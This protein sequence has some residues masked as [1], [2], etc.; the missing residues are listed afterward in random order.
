[1]ERQNATLHETALLDASIYI[2]GVYRC[3]L[4]ARFR[5]LQDR[6]YRMVMRPCKLTSRAGCSGKLQEWLIAL[7]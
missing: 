1:M 7:P 5:G 3:F 6:E 2:P 4:A